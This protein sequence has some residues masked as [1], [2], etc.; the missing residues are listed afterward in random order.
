MHFPLLSRP[1][2]LCRALANDSEAGGD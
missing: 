1:V 2:D